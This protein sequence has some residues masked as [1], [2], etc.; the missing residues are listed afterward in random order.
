M[1]QKDFFCVYSFNLIELN[2]SVINHV[3]I[4]IS[5]TIHSLQRIPV[6]GLL[7]LAIVWVVILKNK[8]YFTFYN[9]VKP[10]KRVMN[11]GTA[12]FGIKEL[13]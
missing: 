12:K 9:Q 4:D 8:I 10:R 11:T 5:L 6:F 3:Q 13:T 7:A 1:D 2:E